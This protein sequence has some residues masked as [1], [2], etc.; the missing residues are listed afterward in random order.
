MIDLME[1]NW[2]SPLS[3][4][5]SALVSL[6]TGTLTPPGVA[7]DLLRAFDMREEAYQTFNR[8]GLD[9]DPLSVKF[10]DKMTKQKLNT[11]SPMSTKTS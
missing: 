7:N 2:L 10:H 4:D 3:P 1:N 9:D 8:T 5:E 11:F 6:S